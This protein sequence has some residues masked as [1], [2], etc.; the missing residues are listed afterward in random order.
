MK[1]TLLWLGLVVVAL[2]PAGGA[3]LTLTGCGKG[4]SCESLCSDSQSSGCGTIS[5]DCGIFCSALDNV[6]QEGMCQ[7]E[8]DNY[9]VCLSE[10]TICTGDSRC[11]GQKNSL[12]SCV[13]AYC[14]GHTAE[15]DCKTITAA[16]Q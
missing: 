10:G 3:S 16:L 11:G 13:V 8:Y 7:T 14:V 6:S 4:A 12:S 2:T 15:A 9:D 1:R 5:G